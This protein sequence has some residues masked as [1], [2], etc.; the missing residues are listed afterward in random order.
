M[1]RQAAVQVRERS[2]GDRYLAAYIVPEDSAAP[3]M[4]LLR[5]YCKQK[6]PDYMTPSVIERLDRMP[7]TSSGK[8][9]Y[10]AL[11]EPAETGM[12]SELSFIAPRTET[13][14][15]IAG[16]WQEVLGIRRVGIHDTFFDLG[17]HS[18]LATQVVSRM[19]QAL[20]MEIS[21]RSFFELMTIAGIAM[22][23]DKVKGI[24]KTM[25]PTFSRPVGNREEIE[26]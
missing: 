13:E 26:L 23:V 2:G 3:D 19:K 12:A 6:L 1:V 24:R 16:I 7:L 4:A 17:G 9:D 20:E 25:N 10:R 18:L 15:I 5:D 14:Q 8:I 11:P 21:L 22:Y